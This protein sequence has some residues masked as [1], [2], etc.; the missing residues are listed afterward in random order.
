MSSVV[1]EEVGCVRLTVAT[2]MHCNHR[3]C[4][5]CLTRHQQPIDAQINQLTDDMNKLLLL[6]ISNDNCNDTHNHPQTSAD[7]QYAEAF[8]QI[9][10]WEITMKKKIADL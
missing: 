3:L 7:K 2:C 8:E 10:L 4:L 6:T 5:K 9:N 1:C